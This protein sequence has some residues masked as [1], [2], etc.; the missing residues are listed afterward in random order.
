MPTAGSPRDPVFM[1]HHSNFDRIWAYWNALG[2][3]NTGGMD[4]ATQ[5][6]WQEMNFKDNY[7]K[8]DGTP[9]SM[10]VKDV[11]RTD[12]LGYTYSG[13][14]SADKTPVDP[15]RSRR[16]LS[17]FSTGEAIKRLDNLQILPAPNTEAA[18]PSRPLVKKVRMHKSMRSLVTA[19][20][21]PATRT[22]EVFA[23]IKDIAVTPNVEAVRVFVNA[24]NL[25]SDT[26]DTDPHFVTHIS[27]L[28]HGA[29]GHHKAPPS[30]LVDLTDT[31][32]N[33]S[34]QGLLRDD[35]IS[36][37]LLPVLREGTTDGKA[38]VIPASIEI[39]VL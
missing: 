19:E 29:D 11:Q 13:L 6:L 39:A 16:L 20:A 17:L 3:S 27:F 15:E 28:K 12:V 14:P 32:K 1:M 38:E 26:P 31:L 8:P 24:E 9:Y 25:S 7:L 36:V 23:L 35:T 21:A 10:V 37:H 34:K 2:R 22:P 4:P 30:T 5:K 18:T 33:L